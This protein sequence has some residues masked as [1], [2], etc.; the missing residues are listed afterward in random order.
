MFNAFARRNPL[1]SATELF[2]KPKVS[3]GDYLLRE[4]FTFG[5]ILVLAVVFIPPSKKLY[6]KIM[7]KITKDPKYLRDKED[8]EKNA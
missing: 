3:F 4:S 7:Y 5:F 2:E 6:R 1:S 8:E